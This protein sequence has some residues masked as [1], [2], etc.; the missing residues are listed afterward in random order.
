L[1]YG[2]EWWCWSNMGWLDQNYRYHVS[3]DQL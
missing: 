1:L 2:T 3:S